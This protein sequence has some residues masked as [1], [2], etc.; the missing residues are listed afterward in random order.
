M[1]QLNPPYKILTNTYNRIEMRDICLYRFAN[2]YKLLIYVEGVQS[3]YCA[4]AKHEHASACNHFCVGISDKKMSIEFSC[5]SCGSKQLV[6]KTSLFL[7][8]LLHCGWYSESSKFEYKCKIW[9]GTPKKKRNKVTF[10]N[11]L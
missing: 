9:F 11:Y 3:K 1:Q 6:M 10:C 8:Q 2:H 4:I 5:Q 7:L